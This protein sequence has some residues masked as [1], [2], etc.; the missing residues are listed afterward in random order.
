MCNITARLCHSLQNLFKNRL[1]SD[2]FKCEINFMMQSW[3]TLMWKSLQASWLVDPSCNYCRILF[4]QALHKIWNIN[5]SQNICS[6]H[7]EGGL[8]VLKVVLKRVVLI[9][10]ELMVVAAIRIGRSFAP[11]NQSE[12]SLGNQSTNISH[13]RHNL[14]W[15]LSRQNREII[16]ECVIRFVF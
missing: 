12:M 9:D 15:R 6:E 14:W 3:Q 5:R 2:S 10:L 11:P 7:H 8:S 16:R 4:I 1:R 13:H